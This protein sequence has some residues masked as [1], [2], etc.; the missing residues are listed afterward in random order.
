MGRLGG[1]ALAVALGGLAAALLLAAAARPAW[2]ATAQTRTYP[3]SNPCDTTLQACIDGA[4]PGDTIV[5]QPNTYL[6]SVTLSKAVSL[7]GVN[8]ATVILH[9]LPNQRVLTATGAVV[10]S[11]VVISGL[12]FTGGSELGFLGSGGGLLLVNG[13]QPRLENIRVINNQASFVGGGIFGQSV[14]L[15]NS[16]VQSNT[17]AVL[18]G[19]V[20]TFV[21]ATL[22]GSRLEANTCTVDGCQGGGLYASTATLTGTTFYTNT[23][24]LNGGGLMANTAVTLSGGLFQQNACT[25]AGCIGGGLYTS[26]TLAAVGSVFTGNVAIFGGGGASA[27]YATL[28]GVLFQANASSGTGGG[29]YANQLAMTDSVVMSN[30]ASDYGGGVRVGG[31]ATLSG[32]LFQGNLSPS[33]YGGGIYFGAG[34]SRLDAMGTQ[35]IEN[36][37]AIGGGGAG[38]MERAVLTNT[39]FLNNACL[40]DGCTGGGLNAFTLFIKDSHVL[41]NTSKGSG[42][43]S[44]AYA[45]WIEGGVYQGNACLN[46]GCAGGGAWSNLALT[47]IGTAFISNTAQGTGGGAY[48]DSSAYL[49]DAVFQG[50]HAALAGGGLYSFDN[51]DVAG[52]DFL[53]N[54][55]GAGGGAIRSVD[56]VLNDS[57][58]QGNSC[59]Q[60]G[61]VGGGLWVADVFD[62]PG[63][64]SA[65]NTEFVH[66]TSLGGGG[67]ASVSGTAAFSGSVLA[68]N[69]CTEAGCLGGG[70][71]AAS[72]LAVTATQFL[73]NRAAGMGGGVAHQSGDGSVVNALFARNSAGTAGAALY[74]AAGGAVN[75]VHTTIA[76]PTLGAGA[77]IDVVSGTVQIIDTLVATYSTGLRRLSAGSVYADYNLFFGVSSPKVGV[78]TGGTNDTSGD[79]RFINPAADDYHLRR[80]SAA[81]DAGADFAIATDFDGDPRPDGPG[82]DIGFDEA[83]DKVV[84]LPLV[85]R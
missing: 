47:V 66:N 65:A 11:S 51:A 13:A 74:L 33:G 80:G 36:Q 54:T 43:G 39:L 15:I 50:N 2:A 29:L 17:A 42:G 73:G 18:G 45:S 38:G 31:S 37:A 28:T 55:A 59:N 25:Q 44:L 3:G 81:I 16:L 7:T 60:A 8:S 27:A 56:T 84:Y 64:L 41:S 71:R 70:L 30:T 1:C 72:G 83:V 67:G 68:G 52:S 79:P 48:A 22:L 14:R 26:G 57:V 9:A 5:I 40:T 23:A 75:V 19:G 35:F 63:T 61:C 82:F 4:D 32:G 49:T 12:T 85:R 10:N 76:S 34:G 78:M 62:V 24:R 69:T 77:A 21:D 46:A 20:A 6:T 58:L 53:S